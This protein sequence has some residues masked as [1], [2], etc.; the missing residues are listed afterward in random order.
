MIASQ[1]IVLEIYSLPNGQIL[2]DTT[3]SLGFRVHN[4]KKTIDAIS[5]IGDEI[6][7]E[8]RETEFGKLTV[9]K[10]FDGRSIEVYQKKMLPY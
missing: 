5:K 6:K 2:P 3:S 8:I 1:N 9:M 7:N 10:G 4:L